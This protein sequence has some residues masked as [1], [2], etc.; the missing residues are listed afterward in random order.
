MKP[1]II[2]YQFALGVLLLAAF[3]LF[4]RW[5]TSQPW[6]K[7]IT[8]RVVR[9]KR[10]FGLFFV[11]RWV[12]Y[13]IFPG[14]AL[15][16]SIAVALSSVPMGML[17]QMKWLSWPYQLILGFLAMDLVMYVQHRALHYVPWLWRLHRVHHMDP[18]LDVTTAL[19]FHPLEAAFTTGSQL[20]GVALFGIGPLSVIVYQLFL[21]L[22]LF[23]AHMNVKFSR[24]T[25]MKLRRFL[26]TP[27]MHRIHHSDEPTEHNRNYGFCLSIWDKMMGSYCS[28]PATGYQKVFM[29]LATFQDPQYQTFENML[30]VPFGVASLK[31]PHRKKR[32]T[33]F[34]VSPYAPQ[35]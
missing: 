5:E 4:Y 10:H 29:G 34:S 12:V 33:R 21:G 24:T 2:F 9:L 35:K 22:F 28:H 1:S 17:H 27:G 23:F 16:F 25:D 7:W 3:G 32:V 19:R 11:S 30:L 8:P 15:G 20:L 18:L 26:V 6:R 13:L 31:P 14:L